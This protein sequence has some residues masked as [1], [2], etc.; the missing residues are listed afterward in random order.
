MDGV[1][2][3]AGSAPGVFVATDP[4]GRH[5]ATLAGG[6]LTVQDLARELTEV[7]SQ[8][9]PPP[10]HLTVHPSGTSIAVLSEHWELEVWRHGE[11]ER[12]VP[13]EACDWLAYTA[14]GAHLLLGVAGEPARLH[15][16]DAVTL[17][18]LDTSGPLHLDVDP[19]AGWGEGAE[20]THA[21]S[22]VGFAANV[23]DDPQVLAVA[24]VRDSRLRVHGADAGQVYARHIPGECVN[25]IGLSEHELFALDNDGTITAFAWQAPE[26]TYRW[27]ASGIE[28]L[29]DEDL[30]LGGAM[31][32]RD[33]TVALDV[34][35]DNELVAVALVDAASGRRAGLLAPSTHWRNEHAILDNGFLR[36]TI[37]DRTW[38]AR[39]C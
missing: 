16:H 9:M 8:P 21:S 1:I 4:L 34:V 36:R 25:G 32:T 38:F 20:V 33:S 12:A 14:S 27:V 5:V 23:G 26:V 31:F 37:D 11:R 13:V 7:V 18:R 15:L 29:D 10:R 19:L 24:E 17:D 30:Q 2:V 6:V 28:L 3:E 39:V 35:R 22:A